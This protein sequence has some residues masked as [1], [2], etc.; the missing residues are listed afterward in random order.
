MPY[1]S[2][3]LVSALMSCCLVGPAAAGSRIYGA[4]CEAS[5]AALIDQSHV[6]IASDDYETIF[7]YQRG[8]AEPV[9]K[10]ELGDDVTDIEA[11]ARIGDVV[12]WVTSHSLN[13][14]G[15]DKKKRKVLFATKIAVDGKLTSDGQK[16][17]GLREDFA[18]AL[19][20]TEARLMHGLNI[21]GMT[22][23]PGG[24]LL[25]G[26]RGLETMPADKAILVEVANPAELVSSGSDGTRANIVRVITLDLSD[27][28]GTAGRGVRDIARVGDRYLIIAGSE[29]DGGVPAPRLFWW[30]GHSDKVSAGPEADF[31][32]MTPE[33]IVVW[34]EH[35][36]EA[37]SDNGGAMI[38]GAKCSDKSPPV[39]AHFP[40]LEIKL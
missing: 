31:S 40:A 14:D 26:L 28:K 2:R 19:Q 12:F 4:I 29:P 21:E 37:F 23:T 16:Y 5:A 34:N 3:V 15:E 24:H 38:D 6:A 30:D 7:T 1:V 27:G 18:V 11:A 22:D 10:F 39:N 25:V 32:G 13:A 36:A 9:A 20:R 33:A 17:R 8:K 35:D